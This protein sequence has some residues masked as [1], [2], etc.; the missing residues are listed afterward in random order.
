MPSI[1]PCCHCG[2]EKLAVKI[3]KAFPEQLTGATGTL[4]PL[5]FTDTFDLSGKDRNRE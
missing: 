1:L 4:F 2:Q 3:R 5:M